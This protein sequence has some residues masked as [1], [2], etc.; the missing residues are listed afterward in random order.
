MTFK[1]ILKITEKFVTDNSPGILTGLGVAGTVTT[2][3]LA[4]RAGYRVGMDASTQY[5][6]ALREKEPLP[7]DL[8]E[9]KHIVKT[10]WKEFIP[11]AVAG[12]ITVT[13][14]ITGNQIG[15]RRTAAITAAFKLSEQLSEEYKDR[16]VKTLGL[17]KEEKMRA[18]MAAERMLENPPPPSMLIVAGSDVL[19]LDEMSGRYF[20][21]QVENIKKAVNDINYKVNNYFY[22]S[23]TDFYEL[24]GLEGTTF[25]NAVGWNTDELLEVKFTPT[26]HA[27][28]PAIS[29]GYNHAPIIGYDRCQ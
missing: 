16:V 4:G 22:A 15:S 27:D 18:E 1:T 9:P 23:L 19:F 26:I 20:H 29:L 3:I 25:S 6:E 28:K 12:A 8:L 17:Q 7:A 13:A 10:Y 5:H 2:A 11:A 24:I 21:N 14:V